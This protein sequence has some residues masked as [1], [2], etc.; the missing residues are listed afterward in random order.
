ML[1]YHADV[2]R[3]QKLFNASGESMAPTILDGD[4]VVCDTTT[5]RVRTGEVA[6]FGDTLH[7]IIWVDPVGGVWECGDRSWSRPRRR[8]ST[9]VRGRVV[10]VVRN[11]ERIAVDR[12]VPGV[13]RRLRLLVPHVLAALRRR[14]VTT[15]TRLLGRES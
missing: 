2:N 13:G 14:S 1:K 4:W 10:A 8:A 15:A 9:D 5:V 7:R 12:R 3:E 6:D 11:G